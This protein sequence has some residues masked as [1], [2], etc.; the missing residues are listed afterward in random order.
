MPKSMSKLPLKV[1]VTGAAGQIGYSLLPLL[2]GGKVFGPDQPICLAML[3]I[4]RALEALNGVAMELA[5]C[6]FPTLAETIATAKPEEAF[7]EAD[8]AVLVGGFPRLAGMERKD[9]INKNT[10]IFKNMGENLE[11]YAKPSCKVLVV[12][13]PANTNCLVALS[14]CK[15]IP[16]KNFSCLTRLDHNRALAEIA[17]KCKVPVNEVKNVVIWGN[18]SR[19]QY[20]DVDHGYVMKNGQKVTIREA[21][22]ES[23]YLDGEYIGKIQQRGA[24]IIKARK[25]SSALSAANAIC[26]HLRTWL[27]TGTKAGEIVSMGVFSTGEHYGIQKGLIVSLPVTCTDGQ[28]SV[29]DNL[30]VSDF[31]KEKI[32]ASVTELLQEAETMKA[33]LNA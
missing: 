27:V 22:G 19:T 24:E 17:S 33:I 5:D 3:E 26:D 31:A 6:A 13:N 11:K 16:A 4:P 21:V 12:A 14:C 8:V 28:Y 23:S 7:A 9:L 10:A 25:F 15:R 30:N 32:L 2:A 18:H 1:V 29:V 20:P